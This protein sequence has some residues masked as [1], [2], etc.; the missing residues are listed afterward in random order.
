LFLKQHSVIEVIAAVPVCL[1]AYYFSL[2]KV[3][4]Q[5]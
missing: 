3:P 4:G 2:L 1:I 5:K